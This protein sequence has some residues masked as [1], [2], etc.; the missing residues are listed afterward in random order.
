MFDMFGMVIFVESHYCSFLTFR[1]YQ[2]S[3]LNKHRNKLSPPEVSW[4]LETIRPADCTTH[5]SWPQ[6]YVEV[7]QS[8]ET[9]WMKSILARRRWQRWYNTIAATRRIRRMSSDGFDSLWSS[10]CMCIYRFNIIKKQKL[11][12][13]RC[14]Q[15]YVVINLEFRYVIIYFLYHCN[16]IRVFQ[17]LYLMI[18]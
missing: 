14:N 16:I 6:V 17:L 18:Q 3:L 15:I 9:T 12:L 13:L 4:F 1:I 8:L 5:P 10:L 2:G 7:L 11:I